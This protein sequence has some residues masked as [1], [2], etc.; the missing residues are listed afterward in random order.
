MNKDI[1]NYLEEGKRRGF[2]V[3][4]LKKKLVDG[5][6]AEKDIDEAV[7]SMNAPSEPGKINLFDKSQT[8]QSVG[9]KPT[10]NPPAD[11]KM[12]IGQ[13]QQQRQLPGEQ[14]K[15][16]QMQSSM[17][18]PNRMQPV[19]AQPASGTTPGIQQKQEVNLGDKKPEEKKDG[20]KI[21]AGG[22][23]KWMKVGA[24]LGIF[25]LLINLAGIGIY[26]LASDLMN[27]LMNNNIIALIV[28]IVIVLLTSLYHYGF[29][30]VG[31]RADEK[32]LVI[33]SWFTIVPVIVY[34]L[35]FVVAGLMVLPQAMEFFSSGGVDSGGGSYKIIFLVLSI[36]WVVAM[37]LH[38]VGMILSAIGMIKVGKEVGILKIAGIVNLVVFAAGLGFL[39]GV[40]MFIYAV[41]N[42][43][44]NVGS[45]ADVAAIMGSAIVAMWSFYAMI[46]LKQVARILEIVGLFK[47]SSKYE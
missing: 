3:Q 6:F 7:A 17:Q 31:K 15:P 36:L 24:I 13:A 38:V 26:F 42:A 8:S 5:G 39:A 27:S 1:V 45:G 10:F 44:S 43:F 29:V 37:L 41:L 4:L 35:L 28:M 25:I 20:G 46:G 30:R 14:M 11:Q 16:Q 40:V 33:G 9:A 32:L 21:G 19:S 18:E 12:P 47:A 34:L 2:S 22:E 23:G